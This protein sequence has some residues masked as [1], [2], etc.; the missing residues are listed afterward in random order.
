MKKNFACFLSVLAVCALLAHTTQAQTQ[1]TD[2]PAVPAENALPVEETVAPFTE[3]LMFSAAEL[4]AISRAMA[5]RVTGTSML[6]GANGAYIPE[7]RVIAVAGVIYRKPGDWIVWLNGH[8][9]TPKNLLPEI[10]DISVQNERV[11]LKWFDI[12]INNV[13][14][15][16][17]RPHQTYDIVTG[18][19]LP[20]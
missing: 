11:H 1:A 13:I 2:S 4:A 14:S 8:K 12:G 9:V 17:L 7:R 20:G 19:L 5:G 16:S 18:V 3:S 6:T 10:V 15:I